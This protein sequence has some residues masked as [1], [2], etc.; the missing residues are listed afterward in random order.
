MTRSLPSLASFLVGA[1]AM[2]IA[3]QTPTDVPPHE[4][5][6][7]VREA[8]AFMG[9]LAGELQAGDRRVALALASSLAPGAAAARSAGRHVAT[10]VAPPSPATRR[11]RAIA[12][13]LLAAELRANPTVRVE[14]APFDRLPDR[15]PAAIA[16]RDRARDRAARQ[17]AAIDADA[18]EGTDA[19]ALHGALGEWLAA[20]RDLRACRTEDWDVG[21]AVTGWLDQL[22][23]PSGS[24]ARRAPA[25]TPDARRRT[26]AVW[27]SLPRAVDVEIANLRRGLAGGRTM[28]RRGVGEV[29]GR[30]DTLLAL[31]VDST[32]FMVPALRDTLDGAGARAFHAAL[33]ALVADTVRPALAR[34]RDFLRAEY[35]PRARAREGLA[36]LPDGMRCYRAWA[37]SYTTLDLPPA[38]LRTRF[39][40]VAER[41]EREARTLLRERLGRDEEPMAWY[42][43][44][45]AP[46]SPTL[47]SRDSVLAWGRALTARAVAAAPRAFAVV[48][49]PPSV[50]LYAP[51]DEG[52][53]EPG[54]ATPP[55]ADGAMPAGALLN[56]ASLMRPGRV[57]DEALVFHEGW[58][59]HAFQGQHH[60]ERVRL[61][62][63][64]PH[65]IQGLL[66]NGAYIEGWALYAAYRVAGGDLGLFGSDTARAYEAAQQALGAR[67]APL[68]IAL[69]DG[70]LTGDSAVAAYVRVGQP[71]AMTAPALRRFHD[72]PGQGLGYHMGAEVFF[73]LRDE[74]ERALGA[75]FDVRRYHGVLLDDGPV[76]LALLE[77]KVARWIAAERARQGDRQPGAERTGTAPAASIAP[78]VPVAP[79]TPTESAAVHAGAAGVA[80][81]PPAPLPPPT[82]VVD[83]RLALMS[84]VVRLAGL[85]NPFTGTLQPYVADIDRHFGPYR[86]HPAVTMARALA[87]SQGFDFDVADRLA[88]HL[89]PYPDLRPR[90]ALERPGADAHDRAWRT[91]ATARFVEALRR[92]AVDA[93]ADA[94]FAAHRALHDTLEARMRRAA[95]E[96]LD[97]RWFPA[98]VGVTPPG[99]I[100][101]AVNPAQSRGARGLRVAP[102][103]APPERWIVVLAMAPFDSAGVPTYADDFVAWILP[104]ETLHPL[105]DLVGAY[106]DSTAF[107]RSGPVLLSAL[108][109]RI[110]GEIYP[111]WQA[112]VDDAIVAAITARY[113]L[114]TRGPEAARAMLNSE[115]G[116]GYVWGEELSALLGEYEARR[117][118]YPTLA[119]FRPRLAAYFDSLPGRL[120]ALQRRFDARRPQVIATSVQDGASDVDPAL[121]EIVVRFDRPLAPLGGRRAVFAD[122]ARPADLP[123][124]AGTRLAADGTTLR[125]TVALEPG[126]A[127]ALGLNTRF[128][129]ALA[130]ADGVP[131]A[132]YPIRFRTGEA[133]ARR[134]S[135]E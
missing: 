4:A 97:L 14:G 99:A 29:I 30:L 12:D 50:G 8:E 78:A 60:F 67:R 51:A 1:I 90:V 95:A 59:G 72:W 55:S 91:P 44:L 68:E 17:L 114:A 88:L 133:P 15:T 39:A 128:G 38:A 19:W 93:R 36:A 107:A 20:Q 69:H 104:H 118:E 83:R 57:L 109:G 87:D 10:P 61:L 66:S 53:A 23:G 120:D 52:R 111:G 129:G 35:L 119:A 21:S 75:C 16:A 115:A 108:R 131:L 125:I 103:G 123:R 96:R 37:R 121:S 86:S 58:P 25:G 7:I 127:Y 100:A 28:H 33:A 46:G 11:V 76:P 102:D 34:Y 43:S 84:I 41:Y 135:P 45:R 18:L 110:M 27:R 49:T 94:F 54:R 42:R 105:V 89:A 47:P 134:Q 9:A 112:L 132:A 117:G 3:A 92:F 64:R 13:A 126:R 71:P 113:L 73:R 130:D 77:R 122:A 85:P 82:V 74:A 98:Y 6:A 62:G 65:P 48:P 40:R 31:P 81:T 5:P 70:T 24:I 124:I 63:V 101:I 26:L 56:A 32:A 79:P 2:P 22:V 106:A 116:R 80:A